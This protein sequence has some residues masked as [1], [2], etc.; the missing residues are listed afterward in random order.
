VYRV[1]IIIGD[2]LHVVEDHPI[3]DKDGETQNKLAGRHRQVKH[4]VT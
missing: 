4:D 3:K 2:S 1:I